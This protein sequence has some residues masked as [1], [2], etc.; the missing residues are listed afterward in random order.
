[1]TDYCK[2]ELCGRPCLTEFSLR[3]ANGRYTVCSKCHTIIFIIAE[4]V[5]KESMSVH[6][7]K[8]EDR[9]FI[10]HEV[11]EDQEQ[12]CSAVG[13]DIRILLEEACADPKSPFNQQEK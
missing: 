12:W 9:T 7:L 6:E 2:C 10:P 13:D 3:L 5:A 11:T 4:E 8:S 1:M